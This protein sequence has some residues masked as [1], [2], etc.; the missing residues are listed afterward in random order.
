MI[1]KGKV[2]PIVNDS[3]CVLKWSWNTFNLFSGISSSC[4]RTEHVKI[5]PENFDNFH[6]NSQ[7]L[8]S[9]KLMLDNQWPP[10]YVGCNYC[11]NLEDH[12]YMSDRTYHNTI[13]DLTPL[14]FNLDN[15]LIVTPRI[16]EL[17]LNNTCDLKC[18]YCLPTLS[19]RVNEELHQYG[20]VE[21][22]NNY[23]VLEY[24]PRSEYQS[25]YLELMIRWLDKNYKDL[26]ILSI[27][28]GEPFFQKEFPQLIEY[29]KLNQNKNLTLSI[30]TNLNSKLSVI[31]EFIETSKQLI[32][33]KKIAKLTINC[34]IDC[35]GPPSEFVRFGLDINQW[36]K[37]F[38]YIIQHNWI[39]IV[40]Q[41]AVTSLSIKT[42]G[43]LQQYLNDCRKINPKIN[44]TFQI[45]DGPM[46]PILSPVIF[47]KD[48]FSGDL[49]A[50]LKLIPQDTDQQIKAYQR[51]ETIANMI[52]NGKTNISLLED[53]KTLMNNFDIRRKTDWKTIFPWLNNF[54]KENKI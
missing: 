38:E 27:Q 12:G 30:N 31:Q 26:L 33:D 21:V 53:L 7:V 46:S 18:V 47:G 1:S 51:M 42:M 6:N 23:P 17:Y 39:Y 20:P 9:R 49:D 40:V 19:S 43:D 16:L 54:F 36:R 11:K 8:E 52:K 34:S 5:S 15:R 41:H 44:Q 48:Y 50:I 45:V 2:F 32:L 14:D 37:N 4:H 29:V 35:F 13:P 24:T 10:E 28:G 3:A 25:E 22:K